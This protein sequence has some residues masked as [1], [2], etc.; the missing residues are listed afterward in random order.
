MFEVEDAFLTGA[1]ASD[2]G[3][4]KMMVD[5]AFHRYVGLVYLFVSYRSQLESQNVSNISR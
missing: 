5:V 3:E 2:V 4:I 1:V